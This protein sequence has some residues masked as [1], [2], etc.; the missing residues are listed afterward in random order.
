ML[1]HL[2][3]LI[4]ALPAEV[5]RHPNIFAIPVAA[6]AGFAIG[7]LWYSPLL[8][9]R[10]WLARVGRAKEEMGTMG[11][12]MVLN[13]IALGV[14]ALGM[15]LLANRIDFGPSDGALLGVGVGL[16]FIAPCLGTVYAYTGRPFGLW[17]IDAGYQT[18]ALAAAGAI[19]GAWRG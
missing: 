12:S 18:A 17:L 8:F 16:V 1:P 3:L 13:F 10:P 11:N 9:A 4:Q 7:G 2:D 19:I 14:M 5:I 6:V 15:F